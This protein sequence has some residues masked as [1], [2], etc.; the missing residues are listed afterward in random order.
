MSDVDHLRAQLAA[1]R[2]AGAVEAEFDDDG[3]LR[4]VVLGTQPQALPLPVGLRGP[5]RDEDEDRFGSSGM[6]PARGGG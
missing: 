3:R 5:L 6:Q 2:E 4:R 1:L